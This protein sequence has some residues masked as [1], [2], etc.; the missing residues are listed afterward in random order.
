MA[1]AARRRWISSSSS[2]AVTNSAVPGSGLHP[3]HGRWPA[4]AAASCNMKVVLPSPPSPP[5]IVT[6]RSGIISGMIH[7]RGGTGLSASEAAETSGNC[8]TASGSGSGARPPLGRRGLPA[9]SRFSTSQASRFSEATPRSRW[10][11]LSWPR[12]RLTTRR[13][14][15]LSDDAFDTEPQRSFTAHEGEIRS[16]PGDGLFN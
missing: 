5:Q 12:L 16:A 11:G 9:S 15:V 4:L 3:S 6:V 2:S 13:P 14:A 10:E 7:R 8:A 1:I